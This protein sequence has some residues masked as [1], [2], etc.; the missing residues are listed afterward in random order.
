[1]VLIIAYAF[2]VLI[3]AYAFNV[4]IIA[5]AFNIL[6]I[7]ALVLAPAFAL[8]RTTAP[9]SGVFVHVP[10]SIFALVLLFVRLPARAFLLPVLFVLVL[11]PCAVAKNAA[12]D[13]SQPAR[14]EHECAA[15][16]FFFGHAL[17][18]G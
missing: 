11:I 9:A 8:V 12:T 2:N 5:R 17:E 14:G 6:I 7:C 3:I 4:L 16:R 18:C 1:L 13:L 15:H 10:F